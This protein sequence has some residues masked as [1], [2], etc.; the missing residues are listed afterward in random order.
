MNSNL[1]KFSSSSF[2]DRVLRGGSRNFSGRSCRVSDRGHDKWYYGLRLV[3]GLM[4]SESIAV[5]S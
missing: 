5:N 4:L 2:S 3:C 1:I